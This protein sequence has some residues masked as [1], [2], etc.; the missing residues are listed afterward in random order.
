[1]MRTSVT[2]ALSLVLSC[3]LFAADVPAPTSPAAVEAEL[4]RLTQENLDA[5]APGRVEVLRRNLHERFT[6]VDENNTV[7]DK[8]QMLAELSPLPK[9]LTGNLKIAKFQMT[10]VG[11][12]AI[13]THEDLEH[14]DYHG[15]MLIS[16]W[17]STDTWLR[18]EGGWKLL[19][20]QTMAL[21]EDPPSMQLAKDTLCGYAGTYRLTAE[22]TETIRCAEG[23]LL[24]TR[25]GRPEAA[26]LAEVPDVFF[27]P[28]R[29]RTRRIFQRDA[30]GAITGYVDR[31]EGLDIRWTKVQ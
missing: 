25:T 9:G 16:R 27:T 5:I 22:I 11:E 24:G 29:A 30:E 2:L 23:K 6:H 8:S 26:F 7:R 28:G 21:L 3:T 13:A 14:L 12:V 1:M 19:A 4:R 31:R 18:T 10:L 15:Q 17:R 20:E